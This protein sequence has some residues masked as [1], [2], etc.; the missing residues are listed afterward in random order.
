[1]NYMK[2]VKRLSILLLSIFSLVS[3]SSNIPDDLKDFLKPISYSYANNNISSGNVLSYFCEL[4]ENGTIVGDDEIKFSFSRNSDAT[5]YYMHSIETF[6]GNKIKDSLVK[7]EKKV[8]LNTS[9]NWFYKEVLNN[10]NVVSS[11]VLSIYDVQTELQNVFYTNDTTYKYGGLY[12]GDYFSV[13]SNNSTFT[14]KIEDDN[15]IFKAENDESYIEGAIANQI[16]AIEKH[17]MLVNCEQQIIIKDTNIIAMQDIKAE[18][19]VKTTY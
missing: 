14:Y 15:L 11:K 12:Y 5:E 9:D 3:C 18:Y 8:Y 13:N 10:D 4:D 1:M 19:N 7:I 6:K 17:G 2:N 16:L